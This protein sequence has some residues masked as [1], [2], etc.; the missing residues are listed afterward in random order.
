MALSSGPSLTSLELV[1]HIPHVEANALVSTL[2][3][4]RAKSL[5]LGEVSG[6]VVL[7]DN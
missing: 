5:I 6:L 1:I 3:S 7:P 4:A 2:M